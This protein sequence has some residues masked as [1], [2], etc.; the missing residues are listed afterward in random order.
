MSR[1]GAIKP[2]QTHRAAI[3]LKVYVDQHTVTYGVSLWGI[4]AR[5][6]RPRNP[7]L[8]LFLRI[9]ESLRGGGP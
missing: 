8:L 2:K 3:S 7:L 9:A 1:E 4:K 6:L 5:D